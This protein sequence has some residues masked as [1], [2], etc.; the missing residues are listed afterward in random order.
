[1]GLLSGIKGALSGAIAGGAIGIP[2]IFGSGAGAV[3]GA[4]DNEDEVMS[5]LDKNRDL[6]QNL[7]TPEY[8][9][10]AEYNPDKYSVAGVYDP[11]LAQ[12]ETVAQDPVV[13]QMQLSALAKM[14]GLAENGLSEV[15]E[16][17]FV[18]A[19]N[20]GGQMARS[21]MQ[22]ALQDAQ[23]RGVSGSGLEFALREQANQGGA[24]RAQEAALEQAAKSAQMR[25]INKPT[26][27]HSRALGVR[28]LARTQG[29]LTS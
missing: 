23:A 2:G 14:A 21:G 3:V 17:A 8:G 6:Y 5:I 22:A 16:A 18:K 19:Q 1:M 26:A 29:M 11:T 4:Q 7:A 25:F 10:L 28:T 27:T 15:D 12:A 9:E 13:R 24:Q 20:M